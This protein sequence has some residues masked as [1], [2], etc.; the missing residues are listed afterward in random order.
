MRKFLKSIYEIQDRFGVDFAGV[1]RTFSFGILPTPDEERRLEEWFDQ[2]N[3][4]KENLYRAI[5]D[6]FQKASSHYLGKK[7]DY[8]TFFKGK[9]ALKG[10]P[11]QPLQEGLRMEIQ[12]SIRS[13]ITNHKRTFEEAQKDS[14]FLGKTIEKNKQA[15]GDMDSQAASFEYDLVDLIGAFKKLEHADYEKVRATFNGFQSANELVDRIN[16][17]IGDYNYALNQY[18]AQTKIKSVRKLDT[19]NRLSSFPGI[20]LEP[21]KDAETP[22][23]ELE[24]L[25]QKAP[26]RKKVIAYIQNLA[27][28]ARPWKND[29]ET[30]EKGSSRKRVS[31]DRR[32]AYW[33]EKHKE[34]PERKTKI[35]VDLVEKKLKQLKQHTTE[36]PYDGAG[37]TQYINLLGLRARLA[38]GVKNEDV[39]FL[40]SKYAG[41]FFRVR[42]ER[43]II[44]FPGFSWGERNPLKNIAFGFH[45]SVDK[46]RSTIKKL[47]I[48]I[49]TSSKPFR[50]FKNPPPTSDFFFLKT[51]GGSKQKAARKPKT[52]EYLAGSF[53]QSS[54][55][56]PLMLPLHFGKSQARRYVTNTKWGL[57]SATPR[58]FL[59]NARLKRTKQNPGDPWRYFLDITLSADEKVYGL[60][61]FSQAILRRA[62]AIIGIDRGEANPI[63]Y[64][65]V[66]RKDGAVIMRGILGK[67]E[68]RAKLDEYVKKKELQQ[69]RWRL[70]AKS[71]RE[72]IARLQKTT[73][74]TAISEILHLAAIHKATIAIEDLGGRFR[75]AERS[76]V[77]RKTY[78]KIETLLANSLNFA[79]LLRIAPR[80]PKYWGNLIFVRPYATSSTCAKC[81]TMWLKKK[82]DEKAAAK[83]KML[84]KKN[85]RV[86][87][88]DEIIT[89]SRAKNFG[90]IDIQ[91][92]KIT[93]SRSHLSLNSAWITYNP[94]R[95]REEKWTLADL[96]KAI[97]EKNLDKA[98]HLLAGALRHR[99]NRDTFVCHACGFTDDADMNAAVNIARRGV[100]GI[101]RILTKGKT[102]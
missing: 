47:F 90:N 88:L 55:G 26:D 6:D 11:T 8:G 77:P 51:T 93:C 92:G 94:F 57:F 37:R 69:S 19:L 12:G 76:I 32:L 54:E 73:L 39:N 59:N 53:D 89:E 75:G 41:E 87:S 33:L 49:A 10:I 68:Y 67:K 82:P 2:V 21:I 44:T 62:E 28:K 3:A 58:I 29:G 9:A 40:R 31:F 84:A 91:D 17:S 46:N 16:R 7:F 102:P 13:F 27:E 23:A 43:E 52:I 80:E 48:C 78:K 71:L 42:S 85:E 74:E 5:F 97:S 35:F 61:Q 45:G 20:K 101:S 1:S 96:K 25:G 24:K 4:I 72:K 22:L 86:F 66:S 60:K 100:E 83:R 14:E 79:G 56:T 34:T 18:S 81:G 64:A 98:E 36:K 65:V 30:K 50:I 99:P 15:I 38:Q 63:A 70:I 95:R